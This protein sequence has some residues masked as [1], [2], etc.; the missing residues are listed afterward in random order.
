MEEISKEVGQNLDGLKEYIANF[1]EFCKERGK[2]R[3]F[4]SKDS[5]EG[6]QTSKKLEKGEKGSKL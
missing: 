4:S 5:P 2:K 3:G 1:K 6:N